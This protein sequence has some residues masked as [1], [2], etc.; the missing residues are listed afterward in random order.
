ML[1]VC[2]ALS[3]PPDTMHTRKDEKVAS[4]PV[5][6]RTEL[7][8]P[9]RESE[10]E[11]PSEGAAVWALKERDFNYWDIRVRSGTWS[12]LAR[13]PPQGGGVSRSRRGA[14]SL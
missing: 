4:Q 14:H 13:F 9:L 5:V 11:D 7:R 1:R 8:V 6:V 2:P 3:L 12:V 10:E